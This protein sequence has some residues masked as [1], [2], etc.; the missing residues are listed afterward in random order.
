MFLSAP[1]G[2]LSTSGRNHHSINQPSTEAQCKISY[3]AVRKLIRRE[4]QEPKSIR[5]ELQKDLKSSGYTRHRENNR[6]CTPS[7]RSPFAIAPENPITESH[8]TFAAEHLEKPLDDLDNA[9]RVSA[10]IVCTLFGGEML[11]IWT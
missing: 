10:T 5:K 3:Q 7:P 8:L 11:C 1:L 2:P 6:Q 9:I 4:A